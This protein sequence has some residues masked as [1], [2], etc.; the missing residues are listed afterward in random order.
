M[1]RAN[2]AAPGA[3][4]TKWTCPYCL[5]HCSPQAHST[6]R[7]LP[8]AWGGRDL[9]D[10][11]S[12]G[13]RRLPSVAKEATSAPRPFD[14]PAICLQG[15]STIGE[16]TSSIRTVPQEPPCPKLCGWEPRHGARKGLPWPLTRFAAELGPQATRPRHLGCWAKLG[17]RAEAPNSPHGPR[18]GPRLHC[19]LRE[20]WAEPAPGGWKAGV[21]GL[22]W[23][24][25]GRG[26]GA[27]IRTRLLSTCS[28]SWCRRAGRLL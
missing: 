13:A 27:R 5:R 4:V 9:G 15:K 20:L 28:T 22:C 19:D 6:G 23:E 14:F 18:R 11:G 26:G 1:G 7:S 25:A 12:P 2:P 16:G 21:P 10:R 3:P 24:V 8:G 17:E